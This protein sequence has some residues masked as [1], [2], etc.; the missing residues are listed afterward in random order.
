VASR[1]CFRTS[2]FKK[3]ALYPGPLGRGQSHLVG[4]YR[5]AV[6][7][8]KLRRFLTHLELGYAGSWMRK[9]CDRAMALAA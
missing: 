7:R 4:I 8:G 5:L 1:S 6:P 9:A 2:A 3:A